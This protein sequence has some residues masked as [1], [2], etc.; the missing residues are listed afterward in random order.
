VLVMDTGQRLTLTPPSGAL[1]P[2]RRTRCRSVHAIPSLNRD[3]P[4]G[5]VNNREML[6]IRKESLESEAATRLIGALN[7]ELRG[8]YPEPGANH[9]RLDAEEIG[10]GRVGAGAGRVVPGGELAALRL[11]EDLQGRERRLRRGIGH[12]RFGVHDEGVLPGSAV[13]E[14]QR[15]GGSAWN[16]FRGPD[17]N[18]YEIIGP[19]AVAS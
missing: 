19:D 4:A 10:E 5:G 11:G 18:V 9:F 13:G 6:E 17:G 1:R 12:H 15:D 14:P 2:P 3:A 7:V 16:H 8:A